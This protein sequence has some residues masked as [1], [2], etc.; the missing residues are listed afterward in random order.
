MALNMLGWTRRKVCRQ[1]DDT[2][3]I[4]PLQEVLLWYSTYKSLCANLGIRVAE[5]VADKAFGVSEKGSILGLSFD[6]SLWT[7]SM[8]RL[9]ADKILRLLHLV[10]SDRHLLQRDLAKLVG[11]L[12]F[13][14]D[15]FCAKWERS[16]F[17]EHLDNK[18][19]DD[20]TPVTVTENMVSQA[21]W[22]ID[23]IN[24]M[25]VHPAPIPP[26][27]PPQRSHN[28]VIFPDAAGGKGAA[29]TGYGAVVW[30]WPR[31][32]VAHYWPE[33]VRSGLSKEGE[34][35]CN[36]MYLLEAV[37]ILAGLVAD[38]DKVRNNAVAVHTDNAA[39][40]FGYRRKHSQELLGWTVLKAAHDVSRGL[41]ASLTVEKV[42]R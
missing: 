16:F 20:P 14:A 41:N 35:L 42:R 36:K 34:E 4:G 6:L 39:C 33:S 11:K 19:K 9:K 30:T 7:W 12:T 8:D 2:I 26:P 37:A 24:M 3:F 28:L 18:K 22:W 31:V 29:G 40:V 25:L 15:I 5:E 10:A 32:Y 21:D 38:V 13:Y 27:S 23:Q 17:L 1:L